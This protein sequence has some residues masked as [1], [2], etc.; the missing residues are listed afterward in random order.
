MTLRCRH[1]ILKTAF[2]L[3][4][5]AA[6]SPKAE[7]QFKKEAFSQNYNQTGQQE[8]PDSV[9]QLFSLKNYFRALAHKEEGKVGVMFG[10]SA[11]FVGGQQIYNKQYWKLPLVY[12]SIG[13]GIGGGIYYNK[14]YKSS[15]SAYNA[16]FE[17][18][19]NTSLTVDGRAKTLSTLCFAAAGAAYW[20]TLMDG[21]VNYGRDSEDDHHAG[22]ATIYS[23]LCPGLGQIYNGE[24]WKV[25]IYWGAIIGGLHYAQFNN[26]QQQRF[27][28]IYLEATTDSAYKENI[29]AETAKYY[30]DVYERYKEYSVLA[31]ALFYLI[32]VID[33]NVF[34]Y[35]RDFDVSDDIS[36]RVSPT[37]I[38]PDSQFAFAG[39]G[40]GVGLSLGFKF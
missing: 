33:A 36:M 21:V 14:Q 7:A 5:A 20:G 3:V 10:G 4:C 32:Q 18:D 39:G 17:L 9:E 31:T 35:M 40:T 27:H 12:S 2:L 19:P 8:N 24:A 26:A 30:Y 28:R 15:L 23:I 11:L 25:P 22:K 6:F 38:T 29:S 37:L 13:A 1:I 34:A 16:A